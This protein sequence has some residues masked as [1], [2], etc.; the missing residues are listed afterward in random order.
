MSSALIHSRRPRSLPF[1]LVHCPPSHTF[2]PLHRTHSPPSVAHAHSPPSPTLT[3]LP[4]PTLTPSRRPRALPSVAH[5]HFPPV[6]HSHSPPVAHAHSL[7]SPTRTPLRRPLSL[8][9]RRPLS[10]PSSR[11][12]DASL[13]HTCSLLQVAHAHSPPCWFCPRPLRA[14]PPFPPASPPFPPCFPSFPPMLPLLSPH[15]SPP[16]PPCF[17]SFPPLLPLLSPH[18]SPPFP[19]CFPSFTAPF[20]LSALH[21]SSPIPLS[22]FH[23]SSPF[24]LSSVHPSSPT[25]NSLPYSLLPHPSSP[26]P[27]S[28]LR[29]AFPFP[30]SLDTFLIANHNPFFRLSTLSALRP[31]SP[32]SPLFPTPRFR[33]SRL[34]HP[35]CPSP[36]SSF[37]LSTLHPSSPFHSLPFTLLL[38]FP[39]L[40]TP[41]FPASPLCQTLIFHL[42][43]LCLTPLLSPFHPLR[44]TPFYPLFPLFI[45]LSSPRSLSSL[46]LY[47]LKL[48]CH[49]PCFPRYPHFPT[50]FFPLSPSRNYL[51]APYPHFPSPFF[52][53][54]PRCPHLS[55]LIWHTTC[56]SF[57]HRARLPSPPFRTSLQLSPAAVRAA[58]KCRTDKGRAVAQLSASELA[59]LLGHALELSCVTGR[60]GADGRSPEGGA[61]MGGPAERAAAEG[62]FRSLRQSAVHLAAPLPSAPRHAFTSPP[63]IQTQAKSNQ[64]HS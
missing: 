12:R 55:S 34:C 8:P 18:A 7:T 22:A 60:K 9:S 62:V 40:P 15:A 57:P 50:P 46:H 45:R 26:N 16:F 59:G 53:L 64:Y 33:I 5:S 31:S 32:F 24:P 20:P 10:L 56:S 13:R 39:S 44:P 3:P 43:P 11:A 58:C 41:I 54:F 36:H 35:P 28:A 48:L 6:A 47:S 37:P 2:T 30:L 27:L 61:A 52:S 17:P 42:S 23:I 1:A 38:P 63:L 29:P 51:H 49:T 25:L 4:S 19:T 21:T 14:S